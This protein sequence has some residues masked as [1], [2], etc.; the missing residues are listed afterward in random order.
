MKVMTTSEIVGDLVQVFLQDEKGLAHLGI[1]KNV[2]FL[3]IVGMD[4][5]G[6]WVAH[7]SY[8]IKKI[9]DSS[10]KPLPAAKQEQQQIVANFLV[11]WDQISSIVHFPD[12][13]GFDFPNPYDVHIGFVTPDEP[14]VSQ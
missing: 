14:E 5:F 10:G 9:N 13:E 7:P 4:E 3:K 8:V 2:A 6:I 12:R 1:D 11:R